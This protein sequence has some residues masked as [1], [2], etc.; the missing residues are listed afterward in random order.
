MKKEDTIILNPIGIVKNSI[1]SPALVADRDGLRQNSDTKAVQKGF[2]E[3]EEEISEIILNKE[4]EELLDGIEE[5]SHIVVLYWGHGI[6]EEGRNLKKVHPMGSKDMPLTGLFC[7]SSPARPNPVLMTVTRL[8]GREKNILKVSGFD[9]INNTPV[10]DI[11]PYVSEFYPRKN[12][13]VPGWMQKIA[14]EHYS[15]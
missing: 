15:E 9:G 7:T 4:F 10:L 11:K 3:T 1:K 2:Y 12:I 13:S 8:C 14:D 5:Y 6:T